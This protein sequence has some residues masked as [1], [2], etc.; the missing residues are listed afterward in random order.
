MFL[1]PTTRS[2]ISSF[3]SLVSL[4]VLTFV[5]SLLQCCRYGNAFVIIVPEGRIRIPNNNVPHSQQAF[6]EITTIPLYL[7]GG[8]NGEEEV[9]E[10]VDNDNNT[11]DDNNIEEEEEEEE[12]GEYG[13]D[14]YS[15]DNNLPP[16]I[17]AITHP[18]RH[19]NNDNQQQLERPKGLI[20]IDD[21]SPFH[22]QHIAQLTQTTYQYPTISVLSPYMTKYLYVAKGYTDH[23]PCRMPNIRNPEEIKEWI[24]AVPFD[25]VGIYCE[26]DCGLKDSEMLAEVLGLVKI[27]RANYVNVNYLEDHSASS[28]ESESGNGGEARR[29]K[30][31]MNERCRSMGMDVVQQRLCK[32]LEEAMDFA[33]NVL[34][35]TDD[36]DDDYHEVNKEYEARNTNENDNNN[37]N[38]LHNTGLLGLSSPINTLN[39]YCI[40]KPPRGVASDDVHQCRT[41]SSIPSAFQ[42]VQSSAVHGSIIPNERNINVLVQEYLV[43]KEYV[44]D[45]VS[46]NGCHKVAALW[47]YDKRRLNDANFVYCATELVDGDDDDTNKG[48]DYNDD[49][50]NGNNEDE[51]ENGVGRIVCEYAMDALDALGVR[52]GLS[53]IEVIISPSSG[54]D[55][56][57]DYDHDKYDHNDDDMFTYQDIVVNEN[58]NI[59]NDDFKHRRHQEIQIK[60]RL[61][62]RRK[63]RKQKQIRKKIGVRPRLVEVN[64]RQHNTNFAPLTNA[65]L[66]YNS[67]DLLVDAYLGEED[68]ETMENV[69][70]EESDDDHEVDDDKMIFPPP[71][72]WNDV[73]KLPTTKC[74]AAIVHLVCHVE[75]Q[76][77][78]TNIKALQEMQA[79][80]SVVDME[81]F[82]GFLMIDE[83]ED[84]VGD[85][86]DS[87]NE[88]CDEREVK[89]ISKTVN[90]RTD[91]GWVHMMNDDA[92]MFKRD[93]ERVLELMKNMFQIVEEKEVE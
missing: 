86:D 41:L 72:K 74:H 59:N 53:H 63:Q 67:L 89:M 47:R 69:K 1:S 33:R 11:D 37:E 13:N 16:P 32:T 22:G 64:C 39:K 84:D 8:G 75:G 50:D 40:I 51:N 87:E 24:K 49:D 46:R 9:E 79:L 31:L 7:R 57:D 65:V 38:A 73:P 27:G 66:G 71:L 78:S 35:V 42:S 21:F 61:M 5:G 81:I 92:E 25:I 56:D 34:A 26:S 91:A 76:L 6:S 60:K 19:N 12:E 18:Y 90:I 10:D 14:I 36:D 58:N 2:S 28:S 52:W 29:D 54:D 23:L 55:N 62:I 44:I 20:L 83:E 30:Y 48:D 70:K 4:M 77:Q 3:L 17:P 43:G 85:G 15:N 68:D 80:E 93:Y 82:P 45:I 88:A